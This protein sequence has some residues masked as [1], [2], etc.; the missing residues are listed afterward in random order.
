[1]SSKADLSICPSSR[2]LT[3]PLSVDTHFLLLTGDRGQHCLEQQNKHC[4]QNLKCLASLWMFFRSAVTLDEHHI[5]GAE[6]C[7]LFPDLKTYSPIFSLLITSTYVVKVCVFTL[8]CRMVLL[9]S[10]SPEGWV[11]FLSHHLSQLSGR[12]PG[13]IYICK[14]ISLCHMTL[15]VNIGCCL[16]C[17]LTKLHETIR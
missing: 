16:D 9:G 12:F 3:F 14:F 15:S 1:M 4:S 7:C 6:C 10:D 2:R 13:S 17:G 5:H 11:K 8:C